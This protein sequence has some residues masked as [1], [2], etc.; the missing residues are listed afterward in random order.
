[1]EDKRTVSKESL[2]EVLDL[3]DSLGIRYWVDGGWGVDILI[4]R[5][6][7]PHRDVDI[8]FDG[9][10]TN[11][12]LEALLESGYEIT[13]DWSPIRVELLHPRFGYIDVHPLII[14]EDGSARQA[15]PFDTWFEFKAEWFS[16]TEFEGRTIPCITAEAQKVFHSGY[17][18]RDVDLIDMANLKLYLG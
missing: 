2:I 17:E 6:N 10:F 9:A 5:Q 1:M 12:L 14:A 18:P 7:R 16:R 4:G 3:L 15:G 11:V 8:N 13:T